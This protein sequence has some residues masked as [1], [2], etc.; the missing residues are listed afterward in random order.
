MLVG[1][2]TKDQ[3]GSLTIVDATGKATEVA[4]TRIEQRTPNGTSA[5]PPMGG[6]LSKRQIRDLIA[7]LADQ[8]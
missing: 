7:F 3:D 6:P 2:V 1:F 8:R 5:M 4:W